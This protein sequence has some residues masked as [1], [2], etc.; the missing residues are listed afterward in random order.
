[1]RSFITMCGKFLR[2]YISCEPS[3]S[4]FLFLSSWHTVPFKAFAITS[5]ELLESDLDIQISRTSQSNCLDLN[6]ELINII[7]LSRTVIHSTLLSSTKHSKSTIP[8]QEMASAWQSVISS[9]LYVK[10]GGPEA[11]AF[12]L[13]TLFAG[14]QDVP[15]CCRWIAL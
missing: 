8:Q 6:C 4:F 13:V 11:Q 10:V 3:S 14:V 2:G 5:A 9:A 15:I 7:D 12:R 1:M